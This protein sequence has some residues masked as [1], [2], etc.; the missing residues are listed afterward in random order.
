[1]NPDA[2]KSWLRKKKISGFV[3][4]LLAGMA[5]L[6]AGLAVLFLTFWFT[7]AVIWFGWYGVSAAGEL[8]FSKKPHLSHG[9]RLS[10]SGMFLVLLFIQHFR[11]SPWHW[12]DYPKRDYVAAPGLQAQAGVMGAL[13]TML[14]YPGASANMIADVLLSGPRLVTGSFKVAAQGIRWKRLDEDGCAELL[15][16]LCARTNAVPY[17]ELK[18]AGW[19]EWFEQLRCIEGVHFLQKGLVLSDELR[20]ELNGINT[21]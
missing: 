2:V 19:E 6:V 21:N 9:M 3:L 10:C 1:M 8:V 13:V 15:A 17:E 16:F 4:N 11:T 12:G 18:G 5:G 20:D 14:A 7:Y